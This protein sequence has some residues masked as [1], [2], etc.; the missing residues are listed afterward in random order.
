VI[1][2]L[3]LVAAESVVAVDGLQDVQGGA[4]HGRGKV[5]RRRS[6]AKTARGAHVTKNSNTIFTFQWH[7]GAKLAGGSRFEPWPGRGR[8]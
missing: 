3:G 1:D 4:G 7:D 8:P 6:S 5:P 2:D